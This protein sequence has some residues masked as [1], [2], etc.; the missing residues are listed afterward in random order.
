MRVRVEEACLKKLVE[1][2]AD[3]TFGHLSHVVYLFINR[4]FKL[5]VDPHEID[6]AVHVYESRDD[7][8]NEL[9][10]AQVHT[11][12]LLNIRALDFDGNRL[13]GGGEDRF[14]DLAK[15]GSSSTFALQQAEHLLN[16]FAQ[17]R[18]DNLHNMV[19][20]RGRY[21]ILQCTQQGNSFLRQQVNAR[22][23]KLS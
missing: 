10:G 14:M 9:E 12:E 1:V 4:A 17:L 6:K 7:P 13:A 22:T 18:L 19:K 23:E 15:R 2:G 11:N 5:V 21:F 20:G 3:R 16:G 8:D